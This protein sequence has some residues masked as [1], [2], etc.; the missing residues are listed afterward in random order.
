MGDGLEKV[1][2][3]GL[4]LIILNAAYYVIWV[5]VFGT[6]ENF[7]ENYKWFVAFTGCY[8]IADWVWGRFRG[9]EHY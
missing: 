1:G 3:T 7:L 8:V 5:L 9:G 2:R 6:A 4:Y